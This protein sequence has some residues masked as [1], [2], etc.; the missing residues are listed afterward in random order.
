MRLAAAKK[1]SGDAEVVT[2]LSELGGICTI[3][4]KQK[5]SNEGFPRVKKVFFFAI[6]N[7][8]LELAGLNLIGLP[9]YD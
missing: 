9:E 5:N 4:E 3:E 7:K 1:T 6:L 8:S 2:V